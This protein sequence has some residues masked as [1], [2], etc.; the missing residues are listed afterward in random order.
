MKTVLIASVDDMLHVV[1]YRTASG[2]ELQSL[3]IDSLI[4]RGVTFDNA[5]M[6]APSC[7]PARIATVTGRS[8]QPPERTQF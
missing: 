8:G 3:A 7:N 2:V 4:D 1:R 5:F 6:P